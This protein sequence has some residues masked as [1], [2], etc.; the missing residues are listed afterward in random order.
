MFTVFPGPITPDIRCYDDLL[1]GAQNWSPI[2]WQSAPCSIGVKDL[3]RAH[4]VPRRRSQNR[5]PKAPCQT[6]PV[7]TNSRNGGYGGP[8]VRCGDKSRKQWGLRMLYF[9]VFS[10]Q[11]TTDIGLEIDPVQAGEVLAMNFTADQT[12]P[13]KEFFAL[14]TKSRADPTLRWPLINLIGIHSGADRDDLLY[15]ISTRSN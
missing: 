14:C 4:P 8:F 10:G 3:G 12:P 13:R 11:Q 2:L 1:V 6:R 7:Q 15:N 5:F 9:M